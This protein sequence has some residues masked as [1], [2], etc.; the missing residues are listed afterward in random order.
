MPRELSVTARSGRSRRIIEWIDQADGGQVILT[1][2]KPTDVAVHGGTLPR[3]SIRGATL[4]P[5][6]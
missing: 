4:A 1:A 2:P 5:M 6:E 3:W